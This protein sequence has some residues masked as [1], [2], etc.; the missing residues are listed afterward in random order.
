M[1][2][3]LAL[4]WLCYRAAASQATEIATKFRVAFDLYRY[5]ILEQLGREHPVDL[6]AEQVLWQRLTR[7][8][9]GAPEPAP[10]TGATGDVPAN[11]EPSP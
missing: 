6:A 5:G 7:E 1:A 11:P 8:V 9:L 4:S 3:T 2:G 10:T